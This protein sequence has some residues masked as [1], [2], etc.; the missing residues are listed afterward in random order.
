MFFKTLLISCGL[1]L[2]SCE[3][4]TSIGQLTTLV[5]S[6]GTATD[7][8]EDYL[9]RE[10]EILD[11]AKKVLLGF[12]KISDMAEKDAQKFIGNPVNSF[13]LIKMLSKDLQ[14]LISKLY[15]TD[16]LKDVTDEIKEKSLMPT[17][18]DYEGAISALHRLE[19]T[20]ALK[21]SD[22]RLGKMSQKFVQAR[23]LNS[24][25]CFELGRVAYEKSDWYH[26]IRWMSE[27]LELIEKEKNNTNVDK[28][29]VL[30]YLSFSTA[31]Q[32]NIEHAFK[33]T[34]N[35]LEIDPKHERAKNNLYH[36]GE[37]LKAKKTEANE[38]A[39]NE[40]VEIVNTRPESS[41]DERDKYEALCR[42]D[43]SEIPPKRLKNLKCRY[44]THNPLLQIAPI[45][46]EQLHDIPAIWL[47]HDV[48]TDKQ[49]EMMK[50]MA[51]PRLKR[52]IVRSP[53]T[54]QYVTAEYRVSKSAWLHDNEH[55][56]LA[57]LTRLVSAIT[58]L[59]MS[60]AEEWQIANYGIGGQYEPHYDY[61]RK[62]DPK[63][64]FDPSVGNRIAT[65]LF[66]L[67]APEKGGATVF[68]KINIAVEAKRRAAAFWYNLHASGEGDHL[69]RHAA[70][71][72]LF[73]AKW[74]SNKWIHER[75]QEFRRPCSLTRDFSDG[76]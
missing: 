31:K 21:P 23:E 30:D 19:D 55:P 17:N 65:W 54:G 44:I 6:I 56:Q 58:N 3:V 7:I 14:Q 47:F 72:V 76:N 37:T 62:T 11:E 63:D 38:N 2:V 18:E 32:G 51:G 22:L 75:D 69:T 10:Y 67:E 35:M 12:R 8:I 70:C 50:S 13:L 27:A 4:F 40:P 64:A 29:S 60:T 16:R 25:E 41:Y 48:I 5:E 33:L 34:Q 24:F 42:R 49:V 73:G 26:T 15:T 36:Y 71:P 45:K 28:F 9:V 74:V 1:I 43:K 66:Y 59:S 52:A 46:E 39:S 68:P 61:A 53:V 57:N 20:F